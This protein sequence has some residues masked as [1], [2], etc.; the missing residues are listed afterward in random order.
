MKANKIIKAA[1][2]VLTASIAFMATGCTVEIKDDGNTVDRIIAAAEK[3]NS[4]DDQDTTKAQAASTSDTEAE[5]ETV[6]PKE[7]VTEEKPSQIEGTSKGD[8]KA[9]NNDKTDSTVETTTMDNVFE[10]KTKPSETTVSESKAVTPTATPEAEPA[11]TSASTTTA[12][13]TAAPT[14]APEDIFAA[15]KADTN[16]NYVKSFDFHTDGRNGWYLYCELG[17]FDI[18]PGDKVVNI[19]Y[20]GTTFDLPITYCDELGVVLA[21]TYL[22]DRNGTKYLWVCDTVGN[23]IH[24]TNVYKIGDNDITLVGVAENV[25]FP[26]IMTTEVMDG[27]ECGGMGIMYATREYKVGDDGMPSPLD[28][29]RRFDSSL[30]YKLAF[31]KELEGNII[32]DGKVTDETLVIPY[33]TFV[34]LIETDGNTYLDIMDADDN[35][36]RVDISETYAYH[37]KYFVEDIFYEGIIE[38]VLDWKEP[39]L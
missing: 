37:Y 14:K 32:K 24:D 18:T 5:E 3:S 10:N 29:I 1:S 7:T 31:W 25:S 11:A 16:K 4:S 39:W 35:L 27:H 9:V 36:I 6:S 30:T 34:T 17:S 2:V 21:N 26:K 12:E 22:I 28:D 20:N 13:T 8:A 19:T 38:L 23:D 15:L 33:N